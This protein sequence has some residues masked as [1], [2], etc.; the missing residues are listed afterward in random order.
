MAQQVQSIRTRARAVVDVGLPRE[1][2]ADLQGHWQGLFSTPNY[3]CFRGQSGHR[4]SAFS[5]LTDLVHLDV[6][7]RG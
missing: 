4:M 1:V 3:V 6:R 7:F 5:V 2:T